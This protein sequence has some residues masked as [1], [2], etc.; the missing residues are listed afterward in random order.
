LAS[1][2]ALAGY[3]TT[4]RGEHLAFAI[5]ANNFKGR[6]APIDAVVDRALTALVTR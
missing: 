2:R 1:V 4:D 3:V 6:A 5:V